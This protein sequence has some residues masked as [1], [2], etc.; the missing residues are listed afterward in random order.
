MRVWKLPESAEELKAIIDKQGYTNVKVKVFKNGH[1]RIAYEAKEYKA[2]RNC[3][4]PLS[5]LTPDWF[6]KMF[7]KQT[8]DKMEAS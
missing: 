3:M 4:F 2:V 8:V 5:K 1:F 7:P 6:W